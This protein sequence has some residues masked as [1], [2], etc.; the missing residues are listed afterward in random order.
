M[1][2]QELFFASTLL[3]GCKFWTSRCGEMAAIDNAAA[4]G[5]LDIVQFLHENRREGCSFDAME[6]AIS[7]GKLEVATWLHSN[8]ELDSAPILMSF[9]AGEGHLS[10]LQWAHT[11]HFEGLC[12]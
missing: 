6:N 7:Y 4:K 10:T 11:K 5:R 8:M 1:V 9:V 12:S 3:R 2:E